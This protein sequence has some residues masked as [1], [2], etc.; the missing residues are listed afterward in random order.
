MKKTLFAYISDGA[1]V[2]IFTFF[3][4]YAVV[5]YYLKN[6]A[7][8]ATVAA[9]FTI[10]VVCVFC[11][12]TR[13]R[14]KK[15]LSANKNAE[16]KEKLRYSLAFCPTEKY[17]SFSEKLKPFIKTESAVYRFKISPL[18]AEEA[19]TACRGKNF[20]VQIFACSFGEEA[21]TLAENSDGNLIL[22]DINEFYTVFSPEDEIFSYGFVPKKKRLRASELFKA[23]LKPRIAVRL[24]FYGLLLIIFSRFVFYPLL[25]ITVGCLF[26]LYA[27]AT[28]TF[29]KMRK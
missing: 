8:S 7:L 12:L 14:R 22:T 1:F 4:S 5:N 16:L 29:A 23:T 11:I 6:I 20:P 2:A 28:F 15:T 21:I 9:S 19:I 18:S 10:I 25:Y 24:A 13:K 17:A 3:S 27:L 26:I